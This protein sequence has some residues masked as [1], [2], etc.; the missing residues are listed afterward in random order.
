MIWSKASPD[1]KMMATVFA[2]DCGATTKEVTWVTVHLNSGKYDRERDIAMTAERPQKIEI[3]W[4]DNHNLSVRCLTC[5]PS[6]VHAQRAKVGF[7]N[8]NYTFDLER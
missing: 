2:R 6:E 8:I 4:T 5:R 7:V 1:G 3:S